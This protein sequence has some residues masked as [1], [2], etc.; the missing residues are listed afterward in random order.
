MLDR[1]MMVQRSSTG[2]TQLLVANAPSFGGPRSSFHKQL[3]ADRHLHACLQNVV[4]L[5]TIGTKRD[6]RSR[7]WVCRNFMQIQVICILTYDS[8]E[9]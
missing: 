2:S 3:L 4:P 5:E 7:N 6:V 8:S 9:T 1:I